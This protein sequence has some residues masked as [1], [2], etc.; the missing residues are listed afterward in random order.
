MAMWYAF[1]SQL[2]H[3]IFLDI[4][5]THTVSV[6]SVL[7]LPEIVKTADVACYT[8]SHLHKVDTTSHLTFQY[9]R[10]WLANI[11]LFSAYAKLHKSIGSVLKSFYLATNKVIQDCTIFILLQVWS[12]CSPNRAIC[13]TKSHTQKYSSL[14]V[15]HYELCRDDIGDLPGSPEHL[16]LRENANEIG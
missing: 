7:D 11:Q 5:S 4:V 3:L 10:C 13:L 16:W 14:S 6:K 15:G 9:F 8:V 12:Q 2:H 1:V